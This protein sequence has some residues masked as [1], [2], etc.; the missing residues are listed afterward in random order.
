VTIGER[1]NIGAGT[2]FA[3]YD[4][5]EKHHSSVGADT[6]VGSNS[7]VVAPVSIA[8][9]AYVAAGSAVTDDVKEGELAIARGRQRNVEGWVERKRSQEP[10]N[11]HTESGGEAA[12]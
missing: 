7:V 1:A 12:E 6:F 8:G 11:R 9:N 5:V 10:G 3:N 2:V 4:G